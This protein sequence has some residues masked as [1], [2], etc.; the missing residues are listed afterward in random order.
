VGPD[1]LEHVNRERRLLEE[2]AEALG[3]GDP[4]QAPERA[5]RAVARI[6]ELEAAL[7]AVRSQERAGRVEE[8]VAG[9]A[10]VGGARLVLAEIPGEDPG[11]LRELAVKLRDRLEKE[12]HGAA[13]LGTRDGDKATL[14]AACTKALVE[15]GVT[16][17]RLLEDA[18]RIVGGGAGG[19]P[20]LGFAGGGN[21]AALSDALAG[22]PDRLATLL[23]TG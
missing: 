1:A 2:V 8:L 3:A 17:P 6:K 19:R 11:A 9:A 5:R 7:G 20:H 15:K 23:G 21:A 22:V 14:V 12:G 10:D 13:V 4:A 18:A 16:A